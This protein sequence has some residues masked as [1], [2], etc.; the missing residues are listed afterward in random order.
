MEQ[1]EAS[2]TMAKEE[3]DSSK[4]PEKKAYSMTGINSYFKVS[5]SKSVKN[6]P[7]Y[8]IPAFPTIEHELPE[9]YDDTP[10]ILESMCEYDFKTGQYDLNF[11]V[12]GSDAMGKKASL[13]DT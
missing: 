4:K 7:P 12:S 9:F 5:A 6:Q 11:K 2:T 10:E 3:V 1:D 8:V 13:K